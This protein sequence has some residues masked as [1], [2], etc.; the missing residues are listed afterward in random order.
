MAYSSPPDNGKNCHGVTFDGGRSWIDDPRPFL[1]GCTP[2]A[3]ADVRPGDV[4]IYKDGDKIKHSGRVTRIDGDGIWVHSQWGM[5]GD[6]DHLV[7]AVTQGEEFD[8]DWK[9]DETAKGYSGKYGAPEFY[10][11]P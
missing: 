7:D 10:R 3:R 1:R 5:W 11:C 8:W 9:P 4:V 6:F 2:V